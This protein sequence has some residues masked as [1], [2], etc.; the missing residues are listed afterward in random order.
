M[1]TPML[2]IALSLDYTSSRMNND[3][4]PC[5]LGAPQQLDPIQLRA[6]CSPRRRFHRERSDT[7]AGVHTRPWK[8]ERR[9]VG[10]SQ[11]P[12]RRIELDRRIHSIAPSYTA[13]ALSHHQQR[14]LPHHNDPAV[15]RMGSEAQVDV[16]SAYGTPRTA[17]RSCRRAV[18]LKHLSE[19]DESQFARAI[20]LLVSSARGLHRCLGA[21]HGCP[22][23]F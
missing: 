16:G 13:R 20:G 5:G 3:A 9:V 8:A 12:P 22:A 17:R 10:P 6:A 14:R 11:R 23:C 1:S 21:H 18:D 19:G 15:A 4:C 2:K 7:A